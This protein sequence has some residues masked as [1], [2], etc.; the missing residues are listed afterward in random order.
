MATLKELT[1]TISLEEL[2]AIHI[3]LGK[4]SA[5]TYKNDKLAAAGSELFN[6]LVPFVDEEE[7]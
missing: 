7:D 1:L 2:C 3:A 4:M 5:N 6:M